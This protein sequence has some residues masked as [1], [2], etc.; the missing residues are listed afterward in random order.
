M[1]S[2]PEFASEESLH[3]YYLS[4]DKT[5]DEEYVLS[6][7]REIIEEYYSHVSRKMTANKSELIKAFTLH[8][9]RP[10]GL[11]NILDE[12]VTRR[13]FVT[14]DMILSGEFYKQNTTSYGKMIT[15]AMYSYTIGMFWGNNNS[16]TT[17]SDKTDLVSVDYLRRKSEKLLL[18][19]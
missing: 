13:V 9:R 5:E 6:F 16:T 7:W 3:A 4:Y 14:P 11:S 19:A 8:Q 12:L 18:W 17:I 10:A 15:N 2:K 1:R